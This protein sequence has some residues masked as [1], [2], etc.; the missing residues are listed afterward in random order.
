MSVADAADSSD[1]LYSWS[2]LFPVIVFHP[3]DQ[4]IEDHGDRAQDDDGGDH[5]VEL[6]ETDSGNDRD[7]YAK[8]FPIQ[9]FCDLRVAPL[10][11]N[12]LRYI[13]RKQ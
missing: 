12:T 11:E 2:K 9:I 3:L 6:E 5:H 4:L 10:T 7:K 13:S 1:I 8:H